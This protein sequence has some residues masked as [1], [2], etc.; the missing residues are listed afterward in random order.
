MP[1]RRAKSAGRTQAGSSSRPRTKR[2]SR[3]VGGEG[4]SGAAAGARG[5]DIVGIGAGPVGLGRLLGLVRPEGGGATSGGATVVATTSTGASSTT[6]VA[7]DASESKRS[8]MICRPS[9]SALRWCAPSAIT[10]DA[11][12]APPSGWCRTRGGTPR[13]GGC[14]TG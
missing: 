7:A 10:V 9:G 4:R 2:R 8:L 14:R 1:T 3:L 6:V 5:P 13:C 12:A 11:D